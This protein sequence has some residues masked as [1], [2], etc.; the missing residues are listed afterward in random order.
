MSE[1]N[2]YLFSRV[3]QVAAAMAFGGLLA[4]SLVGP[5]AGA[6]E[7]TSIADCLRES[8]ANAKITFSGNKATADF[9]LPGNCKNQTVSLVSYMAPNGTDGKPYAQQ[10]LFKSTTREFNVADSH[11]TIS[12]EVPDCY[13][14]I[15]L[16]KGQPKQSFA[17][18]TTY[19]AE[20]RFLAGRMG[21]NK[22][23][24]Q[25]KPAATPPAPAPAKSVSCKAIEA[26]KL[27][28]DGTLPSEFQFIATPNL[29]N[30]T[31]TSYKFE[32][33]DGG[34]ESTANTSIKHSYSQ[35]GTYN[36]KVTLTGSESA[37]S[38]SLTC[39]TSVTVSPAKTVTPAAV[40]TTTPAPPAKDLPQTGPAETIAAVS[41][42]ST[43][44]GSLLFAYRRKFVDYLATILDKA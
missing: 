43:F 9:K 23:C 6:A 34:A 12:V 11:R 41:F 29:Q 30:A 26:T 32:F 31:V 8:T 27:T 36:V 2:S 20:N 7:N 33:G 39:S 5:A 1:V 24:D 10:K 15:D 16:V 42:G 25:P 3:Q 22:S 17:D 19:H 40:V 21:G 38:T 44:M 13:F 37:T 35:A 14:Q 4:S 28:A 18:G